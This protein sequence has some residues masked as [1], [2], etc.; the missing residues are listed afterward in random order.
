L[1]LGVVLVSPPSY[2]QN[3]FHEDFRP[4]L[5]TE[6]GAAGT[7]G[8]DVC[9]LSTGGFGTYPFPSGWQLRNVD[10]RAPVGNPFN[11]AW[12]VFADPS[13][14]LNCVAWSTS[15]YSPA[16]TADDWMWTPLIAIPAGAAVFWRA[17]ATDPDSRDGY[18]VRVMTAASGPPTGGTGSIG[19]QITSSVQVFSLAA[20]N[21]SWTSRNVSLAAFDGQS[22]YIAFRNNSNDRNI[23]A[24]DDVAV[25]VPG[26]NAIAQAGIPYY[27]RV[28]SGMAF[29]PPLTASVRSNGDSALS[30]VAASATLTRNGVDI[31]NPALSNVIPALAIGA[32]APLVFTGSAGS[33]SSNGTLRVRYDVTAAICPI[34][35]RCR[36]RRK[37]VVTSWRVT[38]VQSTPTP[39]TLASAPAPAVKSVSSS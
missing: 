4:E 29:S 22:V 12:E 39:D 13:N 37:S 36:C 23:L 35:A 10:N 18:E 11:D 2:A 1:L 27:S 17:I 25:L 6:G 15:W 19:N 30:D 16:G 5:T 32:T 24:I 7:D 21:A 33:V 8:V 9:N 14:S 26:P 38:R 34:T 20:E 28:P 3:L 31:G